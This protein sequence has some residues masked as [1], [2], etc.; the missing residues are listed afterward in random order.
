MNNDLLYRYFMG[1]VTPEEGMAVKQWVEASD[2]NRKAFFR[3][4]RMFDA[5]LLL[6]DEA[7][8][9]KRRTVLRRMGMTVLKVA[10][11][12]ALLFFAVLLYENYARKADTFA[13][14]SVP[15]GQRTHITL[16]DG[17][18]FAIPHLIIIVIAMWH[19]QA[20]PTS[21]W[22]KTRTFHS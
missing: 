4:R 10:S 18:R 5:M 12:A 6:G 14:V 8:A 13:V 15:A 11:V 16:P 2:D 19:W 9:T 21:K 22:R 7:P 1:T 17:T 20:K 3:E